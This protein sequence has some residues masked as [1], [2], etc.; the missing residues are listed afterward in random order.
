M[1]QSK[2]LYTA[3]GMVA[4][5]GGGKT[6]AI[7]EALQLRKYGIEPRIACFV[8]CHVY[9][10][11]YREL[12][13]RKARMARDANCA[14]HYFPRIPGTR[15]PFLSWLNDWL[16]ALA[17]LVLCW[18]HGI[19]IVHG[20][21]FRPTLFGL[22]ARKL[23]R[24]LHV[25]G[26]IHGAAAA[27]YAYETG[28]ATD[29]G[30]LRRLEALE[31]YVFLNADWLI[32]VS[33]GMRDH[34]RKKLGADF[35]N[36]TVIPSA[37]DRGFSRDPERRAALRSEYGVSGKT[38]FCYLGS[39]ESYQLGKEMCELFTRFHALNPDTY[40]L[41][42]S[43]DPA[44][45]V[46][47]L[48]AR[49]VSE[50]VYRAMSVPHDQVFDLVQMADV[51]FLLRSD[52]P[53]NRVSS[54]TKFAEYCLCGVPVIITDYVGDFSGIVRGENIGW[55]LDLEG[56]PSNAELL[57][58]LQGVSASRQEYAERCQRYVQ[59]RL[60]WESHG[61]HLASIHH[62]LE[63]RDLPAPREADLSA[64]SRS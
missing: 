59:E 22:L 50:D 58:I 20:H 13:R 64:G 44:A 12:S 28:D 51:G 7:S 46:R 53:V 52:S 25:I 48:Q 4:A 61:H 2:V 41:V 34:Y 8:P 9:V 18:R 63:G 49:G 55:N 40:L 45:F 54:P 5:T 42:L 36:Y 56:P 39:A 38:V 43:N 57:E 35:D 11:L 33:A 31:K 21:S 37:V 14:V 27:E 15:Y 17:V 29:P 1:N 3:F 30:V 6:R 26:D 16:C 24:R 23:H 47:I 32:L 60:T 10:S 62:R 19:G